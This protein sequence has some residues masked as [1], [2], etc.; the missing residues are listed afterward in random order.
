MGGGGCC[1]S[2]MFLMVC[3]K[4]SLIGRCLLILCV[5][6]GDFSEVVIGCEGCGFVFFIFF[7]VVVDF[8]LFFL[9]GV[10]VVFLVFFLLIDVCRGMK[11]FGRIGVE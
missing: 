11:F 4:F 6:W 2:L 7:L 1:F 8:F 3:L 10:G 5:G 9:E